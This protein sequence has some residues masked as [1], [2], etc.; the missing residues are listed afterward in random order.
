MN[1]LEIEYKTLLTEKE[2]ELLLP[3]FKDVSP[4][5]QTNYYIDTPDEQI[6]KSRSSLRI[7]T[8]E[9]KA[10]LTLKVPQDVGNLEYNQ[11]LSLESAQNLVK[12]FIL[13]DGQIKDLLTEKQIDLNELII[14]GH[15]TTKRLEKESDIGL[16]AL[17]ANACSHHK[18]FELEVE[19]S[20]AQAG[21]IAFEHFLKTKGI[22]FKYASSKVARAASILKTAK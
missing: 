4:V 7:R 11:D 9:N 3:D 1:H 6:K 20:E 21:K 5:E 17:D 12:H 15:L 13:P 8:L 14:W 16:M 2:Y 10:E 19:V 18:D 22:T